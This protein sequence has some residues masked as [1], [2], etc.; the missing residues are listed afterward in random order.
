MARFL[1]V[2]KYISF[3]L[4]LQFFKT[5]YGFCR[6]GNGPSSDDV[7]E[8]FATDH[9]IIFFVT[10]DECNSNVIFYAMEMILT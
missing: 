8:N 9:A 1:S 4:I 5:A 3:H 6:G 10:V 7:F 2:T